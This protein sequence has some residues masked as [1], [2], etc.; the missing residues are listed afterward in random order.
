MERHT[1]PAI[2]LVTN[3]AATVSSRRCQNANWSCI[4]AAASPVAKL[5]ARPQ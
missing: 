2:Q 5:L 1:N 3:I 4:F